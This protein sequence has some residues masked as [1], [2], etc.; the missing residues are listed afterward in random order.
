MT[1]SIVAQNFITSKVSEALTR[2]GI[3]H[4]DPIRQELE[5]DAEIDGTRDAWVRVRGVSIDDRIDELRRDPR[6]ASSFPADPPRV[7]KGDA[8]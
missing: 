5:Q 3:A 2:Y 8:A 4:N 6:F 1:R 7:A